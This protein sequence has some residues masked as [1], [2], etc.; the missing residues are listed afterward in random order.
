MR[1]LILL[2]VLAACAA[3]ARA[4]DET[5]KAPSSNP[6]PAGA[7]QASAVAQPSAATQPPPPAFAPVPQWSPRPPRARASAPAAA[8]QNPSAIARD[9][10][11]DKA[12][13]QSTQFSVDA[14]WDLAGYNNDE[15]IYT[16]VITS[17]DAR[18]LRCITELQGAYYENGEK[19]SVS[20]RQITTVFPEQRTS[21][22]NWQG[23]DQQSGATYSVKCHPTA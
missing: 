12:Q 10:A 15:V 3:A 9:P 8:S 2:A 6:A 23:M 14:K 13:D 22:G 19:H 1:S 16:I 5:A 4:D 7:A 20:D 18:I 11:D 17:H 21:A